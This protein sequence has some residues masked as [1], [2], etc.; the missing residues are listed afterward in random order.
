M[1]SRLWFLSAA[2][3]VAFAGPVAA[4]GPSPLDLVRGLRESGMSDLALEYLREA[5]NKPLSDNDKKAIALERAKCMLEAAEDEP[6]EGTRMGMVAEAKEQFNDFLVKNPT[7]PRAFEASIALARLISIDA[8]MQLNRARR[9]EPGEDEKL[10]KQQKDESAAARPLFLLASQKFAEAA[11][12]LKAKLDDPKLDPTLRASLNREAF[13][14]ELAAAI[15]QFYLADTF[16]STDAKE[17]IERGKYLDQARDAFG[18][19]AKGG[20]TSRIAWVARAWMAE[21]LMEQ[22]KPTEATAEFNAILAATNV[23]SEEGKRVVRF[24]QARRNY[25]AALQARTTDKLQ[26]AERELRAWL[27]S[28]GSA[29]KPTPEAVSAR[30][31][32]AFILQLQADL[33]TIKPKS[34]GAVEVKPTAKRQ[35]DEAEKLYRALSQSDNDYTARANRNRMHVVRMVIGEADKP[36]HDYVTFEAAQMAAL[37]QIAKLADAEK[38]PAKFAHLVQQ[39]VEAKR[40]FAA[41]GAELNRLKAEGEVKER[42]RRI[43]AL[44]ERARELASDKDSPG[45]VIDVLLRLVYY[46]QLSNQPLQAAVLGEY[47]AKT[48]R[49]TGG[50]SALAGLLGINGYIIA[51]SKVRLD[52]IDPNNKDA[53]DAAMTAR[54][55][56]RE[57]AAT[58]ARYLDEKFPNDAATDAA[59]HRLASMLVEEK[60]LDQAFEVLTKVHPGYSQIANVRLLEGYIATQLIN[61]AAKDVPLPPGGKRQLFNRARADLERV[62]RPV[63]AAREEE[64]TGYLSV[65][66]RLA[67]LFLTQPRAEDR[68]GDAAGFERALSTADEMIAV[69]PSFDC[70][71]DKEPGKL[72]PKGLEMFFLG[73]DARTRAI[74]LRGKAFVDAK[75]QNWDKAAAAIEPA[76]VEV[77]K[78]PVYDDKMK[79]WMGDTADDDEAKLKMRVAALA[80]NIDRTR[81][82]IVMVGF[83]LRVRQGKPAEATRMLDLLTK[84]GGSIEENQPTLEFMARDLAAHIP[85]LKKTGQAAEAKAMGEGLAILLKR[86]SSLPN[87]TPASILFLGQTLYLVEQYD[88]ALKEFAKI[89]V[90]VPPKG[91]A[92][93]GPAPAAAP[94]AKG[95]NDWW[96]MDLNKLENNADKKTFQDQIR[97]YRLAQLYTA[98]SLRGAGKLPDAEKLLTAAIGPPEKQGYAYA[99]LDFR[100]ELAF[101]YEAKGA[102]LTNLKDASAEWGKAL[103][104]WT[105]LFKFAEGQITKT[106]DPTPEQ[107]KKLKNVYFDAYFEVQRCLVQ[108]NTQ[109]QK[110]NPKLADTFANVAKKIV[111]LETNFKFAER[112]K[113]GDGILNSDVWE[114]YCDLLDKYPELKNAYKAA[115]GKFFLERPKE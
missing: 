16:F 60:K 59:R 87:L 27:K 33:A 5:E 25:L 13:D 31:Y 89:S 19:L 38:E 112:E 61:S 15:N 80:Q 21:T 36:V 68:P 35:F 73:L 22:S 94:N 115:G 65:R 43:V 99:S 54:K 50:K 104:Q 2:L 41:M 92:A 86:L 39:R 23:E 69:I 40:A 24:F 47:V 7:H 48:V 85:A 71:K 63:A 29:N 34:G 101:T 98:R 76:L 97:D 70:L 79:Q 74:Y 1:S 4:Q 67:H 114:H 66:A 37:I 44:L 3:L 49:S 84:A 93:A 62:V 45:D 17:T 18:K 46:Y 90:P 106:K 30:F 10:K 32:L 111:S 57:R 14:A 95:G 72:N 11:K 113:N 75:D 103:N 107:D 102:A 28:Y 96:A 55:I 58:L 109:L 110:G 56:D 42:K 81:R 82:E 8:K 9:I 100:R 83:K 91:P 51:S 52:G 77:D 12:Q 108:A 20:T 26:G 53:L 105:T 64:V 88:E 6:D 78:G